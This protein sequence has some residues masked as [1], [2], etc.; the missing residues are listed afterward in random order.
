MDRKHNLEGTTIA[1]QGGRRSYSDLALDRLLADPDPDAGPTP[2]Q[3]LYLESFAAAAGAVAS[4]A[5][6]QALLPIENM[7][8]GSLNE[9][10][11][12]IDAHA[13]VIVAED[14]LPIDHCL[15][16]HPGTD[17][18]AVRR[19]LSHPVAL[20]Q[21]ER[22]LGEHA[23]WT[24]ESRSDTARAAE[25]VATAGRGDTAAICSAAC[26]AELGLVVIARGIADS[27][28]NST[29]F[30]L[31][32]RAPAASDHARPGRTSLMFTVVN[33]R[34]ALARCLEVF[35]RRDLNLSKLESRRRPGTA[36]DYLFYLD[37]DAWADEPQLAAAL[38]EVQAFTHAFRVLGSYA[39][40][41]AAGSSG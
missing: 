33:R 4:G 14:V 3:R 5:A 30:V 38:P 18:A 9:V 32:G 37:V 36:G 40:H 13:L 15:A 28:D 25:A 23:G 17:P 19:V 8:A 24:V 27:D 29:R 10:Y 6:D 12:L 11:R 41:D 21:C 35:A 7:L 2:C 34:G 26:A 39:R 31:V 16:A 20:Q 1:I 22:W